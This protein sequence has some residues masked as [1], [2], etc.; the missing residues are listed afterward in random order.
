MFTNAIKIKENVLTNEID[1][2]HSMIKNNKNVESEWNYE[3]IV[4]DR[5]KLLKTQIDP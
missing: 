3:I 5:V 2:I 1:Y 4:I